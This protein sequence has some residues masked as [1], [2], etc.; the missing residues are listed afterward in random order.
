MASTKAKKTKAKA[1]EDTPIVLPPMKINIMR[2]KLVGDS[3]L[4]SHAWSVK[5]KQQILDKQMKKPKAAKEAKDP[6]E[7]FQASLYHLS[8]N[9]K[10]KRYGFPAVAFKSAAVDACSHVDGVTKV[11][12]RG[13]FHINSDMVE[14]HGTPE[15][16]ED[17]V[18]LPTGVADYRVRGQYPEWWTEFEVRFNANVLSAGE[19][20]NLFN[21]GGF[22]IGI[23][24]WRPQ[25]NGSFGMFHVA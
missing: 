10:A 14:V 8:P 13:A 22:A 2:I 1:G 11:K 4:I 12:A 7:Q 16:R 17:M 6:E 21:T 9:G 19:I 23:G 25:K 15:M 3:P 18:R 5:A 24:D 20:V